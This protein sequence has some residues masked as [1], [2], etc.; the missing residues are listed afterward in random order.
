MIVKCPNCSGPLEYDIITDKMVCSHCDSSFL[1]GE[2]KTKEQKNEQIYENTDVNRETDMSDENNDDTMECR[3]YVCTA[4]GA[5][6][7]I[8]N[9][10]SSTFCAYCGQPTIVFDRISVQK[11]PKYIIPFSISK[12]KALSLIRERMDKGAFVPKEIKNFEFDVLRGIYVPFWIVDMEYQDSDVIVGT[13]EKGDSKQKT[14]FYREGYT[15][16]FNIPVDASKRFNDMS[17]KRLEPY[18]VS[19]AKP[20]NPQ[21]LSNFYADCSD[22]DAASIAYKASMR[23]KLLFDQEMLKTV[24]ASD[25]RILEQKPVHTVTRKDY[26]MFPAWFMVFKHKEKDYTMMVNGQTGKVVGAVPFEK[27]EAA[28]FFVVVSV[29]LTILLNPMLYAVLGSDAIDDVFSFLGV[30]LFGISC[31]LGCAVAKLKSFKKSQELTTENRM[32][33]FVKDR[34]EEI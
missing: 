20:F 13:V 26:A 14:Y 33:D 21:Y 29:A 30:C 9:V 11:R 34:Q 15:K 18:I 32:K 16:F 8:N 1:V 10:E 6:L 5:E 3:M 23:A 22:E 12:E 27:K 2:L 4:C 19:E 17:S 7:M 28:I 31:L 25:K 24:K